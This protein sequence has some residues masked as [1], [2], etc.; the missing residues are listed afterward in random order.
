MKSLEYVLVQ[1]CICNL[2]NG[3]I[4][5]KKKIIFISVILLSIVG[6]YYIYSISSNETKLAQGIKNH[7][8][9]RRYEKY[10]IDSVEVKKSLEIG[11]VK[12]VLILVDKKSIGQTVLEKGLNNKF[13]VLDA[14]YGS[15]VFNAEVIKVKDKNYLVL[16]GKNSSNIKYIEVT[17][18]KKSNR[19]D[20]Q[21]GD[22]FMTYLSVPNYIQS[23]IPVDF[24]FYDKN[25]TEISMH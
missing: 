3:G 17:Y 13:R 25:N 7:F 18:D 1:D 22:Y 15:A 4:Y 2:C 11:N 19:V 23:S 21:E 8:N 5:V 16:S 12:T 14:F 10:K 20:V 6:Y 9:R 24:K